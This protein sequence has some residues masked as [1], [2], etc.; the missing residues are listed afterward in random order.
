MI[1]TIKQVYGIEVS[2]GIVMH[3][4]PAENFSQFKKKVEKKS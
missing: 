4:L 1:K 3:Y 2:K